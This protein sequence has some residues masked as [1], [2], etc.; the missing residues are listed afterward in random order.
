MASIPNRS[1]EAHPAAAD[2]AQAARGNGHYRAQMVDEWWT[3]HTL[4]S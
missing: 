2:R 3:L 4:A 1:F